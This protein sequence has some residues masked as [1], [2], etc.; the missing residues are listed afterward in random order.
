MRLKR[1]KAKEHSAI[2]DSWLTERGLDA[3]VIDELPEIGF[4]AYEGPQPIAAGFLRLMEGDRTG[5]ID[6][7]VTDPKADPKLRNEANSLITEALIKAAKDK[8]LYQ[9]IALTVDPNTI[10]RAK[11]HAFIATPHVTLV[12]K[13]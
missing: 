12:L 5:I 6:S 1:Y 7:L 10:E 9:V 13:L 8:G 3:S 11:R 2:I 4:L